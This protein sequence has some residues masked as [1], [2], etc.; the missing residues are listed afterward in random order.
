V[1]ENW[2]NV[3]SAIGI[4]GSLLFTGVSLRSE[5]RTRRISNLLTL[6]A[7]HREIWSQLFQF[8]ALGGVLAGSADLEETPITLEE[9]L[10]VNMIIQHFNSAF[11][12]VKSGLVIKP[13]GVRQ[14]VH[15]FF[16]LP[17][18]HSIWEREKAFQ[19]DDFVEF[20]EGC[21]NPHVT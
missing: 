2:L 3:L 6:T 10:Y 15:W 13:E 12:A 11:Q 14:D 4:V 18:P 9:A 21:L 19:N 8:Q 5:T 20:V 16:S 7:G 17:I 1:A